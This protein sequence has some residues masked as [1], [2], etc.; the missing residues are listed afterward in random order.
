VGLVSCRPRHPQ[1]P[2]AAAPA[3]RADE[4][5]QVYGWLFKTHRKNAQDLRI[6]RLL[7]VEAF[8][9]INRAWKRLGYPFDSLVPSYATAIGSSAD[10]PAALAELAGIILADGVRHPSYRIRGLHFAGGTPYDTHLARK[11]A[12]GERVLVPEIASVLRR[13]L[14]GVVEEGT[15]VRTR[16]AVLAGGRS[17]PVGGKTG[18]GDNRQGV[19][20]RRGQLVESRVLNRT[21]TFAFTV[22]DRFYGS[23]TAYVPGPEAAQYRFT[24]SLAVQVFKHL[25]PALAPLLSR[26][27]DAPESAPPPGAVH[28]P[29]AITVAR[30]GTSLPS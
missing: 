21:A 8:L 24:S 7:E 4:R 29:A 13:E 12:A 9:E 11:P 20:G 28:D 26:P 2:R 3:A 5:Q 25:A 18:T 17:L 22:G 27:A 14:L 6:R 10:R 30:A 16:G 23:L 1:P 19:Y 15:A